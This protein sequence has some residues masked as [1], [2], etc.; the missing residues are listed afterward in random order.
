M[1]PKK[2]QKRPAAAVAASDTI[3]TP[4][5]DESAIAAD[6]QPHVDEAAQDKAAKKAKKALQVSCV[7]NLRNQA[8]SV[9]G[10]DAE[11]DKAKH[12]LEV[13]NSLSGET[14]NNFLTRWNQTK[15]TKNL[16]WVKN[17]QESLTT[18][19]KRNTEVKQKYMTRHLIAITYEPTHSLISAIAP[20]LL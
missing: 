13:Y 8:K 18:T 12:A 2:T 6:E 15:G 3:D 16:D 11:R 20:N 14:K 7:N 17:F 9:R 4:D 19:Q 1:A 10:T 5:L